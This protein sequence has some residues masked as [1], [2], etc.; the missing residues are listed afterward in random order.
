MDAP[1]QQHHKE[2]RAEDAERAPEKPGTPL[3]AQLPA[4][5]SS[6]SLHELE[7]PRAQPYSDEAVWGVRALIREFPGGD[8]EAST[9]Y[10]RYEDLLLL[11]GRIETVSRAMGCIDHE[12]TQARLGALLGELAQQFVGARP[13]ATILDA[14]APRAAPRAPDART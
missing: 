14:P 9:L 12:P 8:V 4:G 6:L 7:S 5:L 1:E 13:A 10:R 3:G 11:E 2:P